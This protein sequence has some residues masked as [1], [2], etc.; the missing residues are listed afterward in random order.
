VLPVVT[1]Y[2]IDRSRLLA[3][4]ATAQLGQDLFEPPIAVGA[5]QHADGKMTEPAALRPVEQPMIFP[6]HGRVHVGE[7]MEDT[8]TESSRVHWVKSNTHL[9]APT[10]RAGNRPIAAAPHAQTINPTTARKRF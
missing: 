10:G 9:N 8:P 6:E 7:R 2:Q 3:A 4:P 1:C 5:G